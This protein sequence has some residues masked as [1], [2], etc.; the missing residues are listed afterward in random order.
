MSVLIDEKLEETPLKAHFR[1]A[2]VQPIPQLKPNL[3]PVPMGEP[4]G[5]VTILAAGAGIQRWA[6]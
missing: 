1:T 2:A 4:Q 5:L 6:G 3:D